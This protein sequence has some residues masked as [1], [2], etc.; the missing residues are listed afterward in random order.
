MNNIPITTTES[1]LPLPVSDFL[2]SLQQQLR[3]CPR[4]KSVRLKFK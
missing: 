1:S 4:N 3:I 2:L